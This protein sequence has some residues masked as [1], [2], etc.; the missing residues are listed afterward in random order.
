VTVTGAGGS[1][2][3]GRSVEVGRRV[4]GGRSLDSGREA[5]RRP[6]HGRPIVV[7]PSVVR[8]ERFGRS[9]RPV[10]V[11]RRFSRPYYVFRPRYTTS[12][13]LFIGYPVAYPYSWMD[14]Y[15]YPVAPYAYPYPYPP[16]YPPPPGYA[17]AQP[18]APPAG[19]SNIVTFPSTPD[20]DPANSGGVSFTITPGTAIVYIDGADVGTTDDF[21]ADRAPLTLTP[22]R[23]HVDLLASGY[24]TMSF[25][26][27]I[28]AGEVIPYEG[29]M[30][31]IR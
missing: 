22:G 10:V 24:Q 9:S 19:S 29:S 4:V 8:H 26:V 18:I 16:P 30:E 3:T 11:V 28:A 20:A 14:S 1:I 5:I 12:F 15:G 13:G 21:S 2:T 25:D 27:T 7:S 31:P 6:D 23:H 17:T